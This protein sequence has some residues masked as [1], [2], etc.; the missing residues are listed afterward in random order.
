MDDQRG[1]KLWAIEKHTK[2]MLFY[3]SIECRIDGTYR[4]IHCQRAY[5]IG[6]PFDSLTCN[7]CKLVLECDDFWFERGNVVTV[8]H[9]LALMEWTPSGP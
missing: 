8:L 4:H 5:E 1:G 2:I 9:L 6:I 3:E 7:F